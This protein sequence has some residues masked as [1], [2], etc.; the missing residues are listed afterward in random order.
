MIV[1]G[2]HS[3]T[4]RVGDVLRRIEACDS[5]TVDGRRTML[6]L[7]GQLEQ[8]LED[9]HHP[10]ACH[11]SALTDRIASGAPKGRLRGWI[12][13]QELRLKIPEGY[14]SY[15][16][17]PEQFARMAHA[18]AAE[19]RPKSA[20]VIGVRTIG[21][22]LSA[23]VAAELRRLGVTAARF[24]VRPEGDPF[25]RTVSF[26]CEPLAYDW[27]LVVDEGPGQSG[28]SMASVAA[29]LIRQGAEPALIAFLS[30]HASQPPNASDDILGVW[31][32]VARYSADAHQPPQPP[33]APVAQ[34]PGVHAPSF[35]PF[36]PPR[37][38]DGDTLWQFCGL[39]SFEAGA[40][41]A[42]EELRSR[43]FMPDITEGPVNGFVGFQIPRDLQPAIPGREEIARYLDSAAHAEFDATGHEKLVHMA[44]VNTREAL[45]PEFEA[46]LLDLAPTDRIERGRRYLDGRWSPALWKRTP[47]GRLLKLDAIGHDRDHTVIGHQPLAWDLAAASLE[48]GL[49]EE[50]T[51]AIAA[52]LNIQDQQPWIPFYRCAYAAFMC[53]LARVC[54]D[55]ATPNSPRTP[56]LEE[57]VAHRRTQLE[58]HLSPTPHISRR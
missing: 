44:C 48:L 37:Y 23:I 30:S 21:T 50:D 3:I 2:D 11:A 17:Y 43:P 5:S 25:R 19:R 39:D 56:R 42:A 8:G 55:Q 46:A 29:E 49:T 24:T 15:C 27:V 22:S 26:D 7:A 1:Y 51:N 41:V 33:G 34:L 47:D 10:H 58:Q 16:L 28:S 12:L 45:G 6:I 14:N 13:D 40:T 38:L 36:E 57:E 52:Q 20:L 54:A 18:F 9:A 35:A 31:R 53:G 32:S 4:C